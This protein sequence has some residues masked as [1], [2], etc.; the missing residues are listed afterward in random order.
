M[1]I[2]THKHTYKK[3]LLCLQDMIKLDYW[4][5]KTSELQVA[6]KIASMCRV[7]DT[8]EWRVFNLDPFDL[9]EVNAIHISMGL[10][11]VQFANRRRE[12]A[13]I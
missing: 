12:T 7:Q 10:S 9:D 2:Y 5:Q 6:V 8:G 4:C 3:K 13:G 1:Y 11:E